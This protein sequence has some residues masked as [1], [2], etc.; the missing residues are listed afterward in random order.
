MPRIA[1]PAAPIP[2]PQRFGDW[3]RIEDL[4]E[5]LGGI[6]PKR[7]RL[8]PI[9]GTATEADCLRATEMERPCELIDG[10]LVEKTM[11]TPEG[12]LAAELLRLIKN[13]VTPRRLGVV[14]GS[15]GIFRMAHGNIRLP[16]VSFTRRDRL[17]N[18]FP[19]IGGWCPDL[20]VEVLSPDN[21]RAE[22]D[23]KRTEYFATGCKLMWIIDKKS[24]TAEVYPNEFECVEIE[25]NG[26]LDAGTVLP[27]L[28]ISMAELFAEYDDYFPTL[29]Q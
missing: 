7:I 10:T 28:T 17:P 29:A 16:D 13:F 9:P 8:D 24:R 5:S 19:Q 6:P 1:P 18:P 22:M 25:S 2:D 20:C 23:R 15:E 27:G 12:F 11:G 26:V 14:I 3:R 4:V 21:T